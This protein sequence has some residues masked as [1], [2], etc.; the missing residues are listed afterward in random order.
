MRVA[1]G[2][3]GLQR[4][5]IRRGFIREIIQETD[6]REAWTAKPRA[7]FAHRTILHQRPAQLLA[8]IVHGRIHLI[9]IDGA[10]DGR[11]DSRRKPPAARCLA[12]LAAGYSRSSSSRTAFS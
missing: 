7:A 8:A 3:R 1:F 12:P 5:I 4:L 9:K 10:V 11:R 2:Q 6:V